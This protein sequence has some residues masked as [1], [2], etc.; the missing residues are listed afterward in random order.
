MI[1]TF[2]MSTGEIVEQKTSA[3]EGHASREEIRELTSADEYHSPAEP[4]SGLQP[5]PLSSG[6]QKIST[7]TPLV[8][9]IDIDKLISSM[10]K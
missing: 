5:A 7:A 3:S 1:T 2:D 9:S 10:D 8:A 6:W 4:Q